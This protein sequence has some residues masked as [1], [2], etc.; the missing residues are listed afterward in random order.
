M[1][2]SMASNRDRM[3]QESDKSNKE[4]KREVN[5]LTEE[6]VRKEEECVTLREELRDAPKM[7]ELN[8]W[9]GKVKEY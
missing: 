7:E 5:R 2:K 1:M 8:R 9:I 4:M 6:L 3:L